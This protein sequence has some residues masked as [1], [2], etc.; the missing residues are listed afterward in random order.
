MKNSIKLIIVLLSIGFVSCE[1]VVDISVPT[2]K[3][4]LVIEA[5]LDWQ[6]G[7][8][9]NNQTILLSTSTP[10]FDANKQNPVIGATV[11][12][13]NVNSN[14]EYLF[15]DQNDGTYSISNFIPVLNDTYRLEITYDNEFYVGT[16]ILKPVSKI[17]RLE[18]SLKGGFDDEVLD[19]TLFWDDPAEDVNF[20]LLKL[21]EEGDLFPIL[22]DLPDEFVNGNEVSEFFEKDKDEDDDQKEFNPGDV[23]DI[24]LYGI[25]EQYFNYM[26]LLIEQYDS[27]GDPFSAIPAKIKGNCVNQTTPENYPFGYFRVVEFDKVN[28]TFVEQE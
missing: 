21:F 27:G 18:Q 16:E 2:A 20:Y 7:T 25:S 13:T 11:K 14:A 26:S 17:N 24:Y 5:S 23:V 22:E 4:R 8:D 9:G 28:Y 15:E 6:K 1:D 19:V 3:S 10:Y 12:V